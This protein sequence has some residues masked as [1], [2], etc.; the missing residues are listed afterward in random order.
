MLLYSLLLI[1]WKFFF[2][3]PKWLFIFYMQYSRAYGLKNC[4]LCNAFD[5]KSYLSMLNFNSIKRKK[6]IRAISMKRYC[7]L[8]SYVRKREC[9]LRIFKYIYGSIHCVKRLGATYE[10][11]SSN[12]IE[13]KTIFFFNSRTY[14]GNCYNYGNFSNFLKFSFDKF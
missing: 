4:I 10:F 12:W 5:V 14:R 7:E 11:L 3:D 6:K 2:Y 8:H 13:L 9:I 1:A